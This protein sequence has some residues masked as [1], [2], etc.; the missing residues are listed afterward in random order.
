MYYC[1]TLK[2]SIVKTMQVN[3]Q[4]NFSISR[5]FKHISL[6]SADCPYL[7]TIGFRHQLPN[8]ARN[9]PQS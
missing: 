9:I 2:K 8:F 1:G 4:I 6:G 5:C 3:G 7:P